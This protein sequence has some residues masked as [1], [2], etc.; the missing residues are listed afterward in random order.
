MSFV[1]LHYYSIV[2]RPGTR[3][4]AGLVMLTAIN[5]DTAIAPGADPE[6]AEML[7]AGVHLG[8]IRSKRH[9]AMAPYVW[10]LRAN[11]EIIDLTKTKEKLAA[12][13]AFLKQMAG[14][15]RVILFVGTRP[16]ARDLIRQAADELGYPYVNQR[17]IGGALTNFKV[18]RKRVEILEGFEH[19]KA[20]GGFEKYT[21]WE[22]LEL[23]KK[24][25][26]LAGNFDGLRRLSK[27]P[28]AVVIIDISH[29]QNALHEANRMNIPVVALTDTNT[30]PRQVAYPVPSN[31]DARPAISYMLGRMKAAI[32]EGRAQRAAAD[33]ALAAAAP[34]SDGTVPAAEAQQ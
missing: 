25:A 3:C 6:G 12:A 27:L 23:E 29:D 14:E 28:D 20:T 7:D 33:A 2:A 10:G 21:K 17:W 19:E 32:L 5:E 1:D 18:I 30:D 24:M 16:S 22:Q 4:Y 31:D 34:A 15:G 8:H 26:R 9:P 11:V 13:L